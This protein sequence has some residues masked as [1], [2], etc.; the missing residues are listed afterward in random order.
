MASASDDPR[1]APVAPKGEMISSGSIF[2]VDPLYIAGGIVA[3]GV[4]FKF[5][6]LGGRS[7]SRPRRNPPLT[8]KGAR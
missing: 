5:G 3:L 4:L 2:G 1:V 8:K 7:K 6:G